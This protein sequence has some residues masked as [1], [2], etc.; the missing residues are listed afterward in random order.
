MTPESEIMPSFAC[1]V[2]MPS[3]ASS[4]D[5]SGS[6]SEADSRSEIT[7][8][9]STTGP[10]SSSRRDRLVQLLNLYK[11]QKIIWNKNFS[12][13]PLDRPEQFSPTSTRRAGVRRQT[14]TASEDL[15]LKSGW[16]SNPNLTEP[17]SLGPE[18]QT[19]Q[20]TTT[21]GSESQKAVKRNITK[22]MKLAKATTLGRWTSGT[23]AQSGQ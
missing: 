19:K 7:E 15:P 14:T 2:R 23:S 16:C 6:P 17:S 4:M 9:T 11:D 1:V 22:R 3:T 10:S 12:L 13:K 21:D 18:P 20:T 8:V 5:R